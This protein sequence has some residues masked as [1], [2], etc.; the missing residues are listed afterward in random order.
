M[1]MTSSKKS[2]IRYRD[3]KGRF[4]KAP[5]QKAEIKPRKVVV[6]KAPAPKADAIIPAVGFSD[7]VTSRTGQLQL[8][9]KVWVAMTKTFDKSMVRQASWV[10]A[11]ESLGLTLEKAMLL[12]SWPKFRPFM[13][14]QLTVLK[15][16]PAL[17]EV[18]QW[19]LANPGWGWKK[20]YERFPRKGLGKVGALGKLVVELDGIRKEGKTSLRNIDFLAQAC[21][22][23]GW[24]S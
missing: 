18:L 5:A 11:Q 22:L 1:K 9:V 16:H 24:I 17:M 23:I 6:A 8:P 19:S 10:V 13:V 7:L 4:C 2:V 14:A 20:A 21:Q 15:K 3:E 12:V